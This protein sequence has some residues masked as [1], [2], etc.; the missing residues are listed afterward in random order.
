MITKRRCYD[1]PPTVWSHTCTDA[2]AEPIGVRCL[3]KWCYCGGC[4]ANLEQISHMSSIQYGLENVCYSANTSQSARG[5]QCKSACK[6]NGLDT[7]GRACIKL[8]HC[9]RHLTL[10][11]SHLPSFLQHDGLLPTLLPRPCQPTMLHPLIPLPFHLSINVNHHN[12]AIGVSTAALIWLHLSLLCMVSNGFNW[13]NH[14]LS[15]IEM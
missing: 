10:C 3:G 9:R 8:A 13:L 1:V 15:V 6:H 14:L 5:R 2:A 11:P 4:R 7:S 12:V